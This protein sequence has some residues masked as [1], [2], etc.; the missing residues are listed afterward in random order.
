MD[1]N[2]YRDVWSL[3]E[4]G[5]SSENPRKSCAIHGEYHSISVA[6]KLP[7][8]LE[9]LPFWWLQLTFLMV[10][11]PH[12]LSPF[13]SRSLGS[14]WKESQWPCE[15]LTFKSKS[16]IARCSTAVSSLIQCTVIR[17]M[18]NSMEFAK[19]L[20]DLQYPYA[21]H[22]AGI[23][24]PTFTQFLLPSFVGKYFQHHGASGIETWDFDAYPEG[25]YHESERLSQSE[26]GFTIY[27]WDVIQIYNIKMGFA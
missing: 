12:S 25:I 18:A 7:F 8:W 19:D 13:P 10:N 27:L 3:I 23:C 20:W 9:K 22:G 6:P 4:P 2:T 26:S 14:S 1:P 17:F 21:N 16:S 15:V 5:E 11:S 24:T